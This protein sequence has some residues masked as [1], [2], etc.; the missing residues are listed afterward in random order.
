MPSIPV[1]VYRRN[2]VQLLVLSP[3]TEKNQGERYRRPDQSAKVATTSPQTM[4]PH[5]APPGSLLESSAGQR[6]VER[7]KGHWSRD[8]FR[9]IRT[10]V[11]SSCFLRGFS[12]QWISDLV[13]ETLAWGLWR[14][15]RDLARKEDIARKRAC[16]TAWI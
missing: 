9:P 10:R 15:K 8:H 13:L 3:S 11:A 1:Y 2:N 4:R 12:L 14:R 5:N 16:A 6:L 7:P